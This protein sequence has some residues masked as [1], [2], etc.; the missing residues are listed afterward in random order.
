[1]DV[2]QVNLR[3]VRLDIAE[4]VKVAYLDYLRAMKGVLVGRQ[5]VELL[6]DQ[7]RISKDFYDVGIVPITNV[8]KTEVDLAN[9]R[10][11]L[12]EVENQVAVTRASLNRLL[13][14]P[15]DRPLKVKDILQYRKVSITYQMARN[16]ALAE[17]PEIKALALQLKQADQSI[18]AA[19][20]DFYP[21]VNL[22]GSFN[23]QSDS[24]EMNDSLFYDPYGWAVTATV[25]WTFWEWGRT[26]YKVSAEKANK[27][28]IEAVRRETEDKIDL[29]VK[30]AY[31]FFARG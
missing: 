13:G 17:R 12:L 29:D 3:L 9:S 27:K 1:M 8:L 18:K 16:I 31:L 11:R 2:A 19:G 5:G 22:R 30:Q 25:D 23:K 10:Q 28:R 20:A 6:E 15:L 21:Q 7:L 14:L 26:K 4:A 24:P